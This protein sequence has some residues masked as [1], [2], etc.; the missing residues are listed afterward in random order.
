MSAKIKIQPVPTSVP[1]GPGRPRVRGVR[2]YSHYEGSREGERPRCKAVGCTN[3]LK[4][5]QVVAC[6]PD[7]LRRIETMATVLLEGVEHDRKT[8][9]LA[10]LADGTC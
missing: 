4:R 6:S 9:A 10:A 5:G 7:C 8:S 1:R 2:A 3:N